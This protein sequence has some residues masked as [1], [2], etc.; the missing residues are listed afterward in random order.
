M[1]SPA[2]PS[3]HYKLHILALQIVHCTMNIKTLNTAYSSTSKNTVYNTFCMSKN[4]Q[5]FDFML[6]VL[7]QK[8]CKLWPKWYAAV[9][10]VIYVCKVHFDNAA[11]SITSLLPGMRYF[12]FCLA[13][14]HKRNQ[15]I[16]IL[17]TY[18][19]SNWA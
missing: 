7:P 5:Q 3:V 11:L 16:N 13:Y 18:S 9:E 17:K 8:V 12:L 10:I 19:L 6:K 15:T 14:L 4:V 1:Y 2:P